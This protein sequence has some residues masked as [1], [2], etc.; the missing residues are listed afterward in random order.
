[1]V[2]FGPILNSIW[3]HEDLFRRETENIFFR[4]PYILTIHTIIWLAW[5]HFGV[6]LENIWGHFSQMDV[7]WYVY[8]I[9][10][11]LLSDPNGPIEIK[12]IFLQYIL[13][14]EEARN[15]PR[16]RTE[17]RAAA[18]VRGWGEGNPPVKK[19]GLEVW[20]LRYSDELE[21]ISVVSNP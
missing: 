7:E 5:G 4:S 10:C 21:L 9:L 20:K 12:H 6:T 3:A 18:S 14:V 17:L 8:C 15:I 1:M 11:R 16:M 13:L 2:H 19:L